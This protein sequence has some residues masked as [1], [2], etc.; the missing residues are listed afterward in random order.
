VVAS[1]R[2]RTRE[3]ET[4]GGE[5]EVDDNDGEVDDDVLEEEDNG[6]VLRVRN[7]MAARSGAGIEDD[8]RWRHDGV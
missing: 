2:R 8:R 5:V 3:T 6:G 1:R 4:D 7:K